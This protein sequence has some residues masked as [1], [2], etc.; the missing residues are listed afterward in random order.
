MSF[1]KNRNFLVERSKA[2]VRLEIVRAMAAQNIKVDHL[3]VDYKTPVS[4]QPNFSGSADQHIM[5]E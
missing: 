2:S 4:T 1:L 3:I 5:G